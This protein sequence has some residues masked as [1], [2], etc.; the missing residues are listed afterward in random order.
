MSH[1]Y[2]GPSALTRPA[3][4]APVRAVVAAIAL[5]SVLAALTFAGVLD[6][7]PA[8]STSVTELHHSSGRLAPPDVKARHGG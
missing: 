1:S 4:A 8:R 7:S 5:L 2:A 6:S 3:L